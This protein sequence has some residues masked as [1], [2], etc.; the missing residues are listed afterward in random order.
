MKY[1]FPWSIS[2]CR[3]N[4][5]RKEKNEWI[6]IQPYIGSNN[7]FEIEVDETNYAAR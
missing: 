1:H 6:Q 7:E 4:E 2:C 5:I 3:A